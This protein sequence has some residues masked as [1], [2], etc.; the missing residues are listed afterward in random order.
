MMRILVLCNKPPYP[1][2]DGGAIASWGLISSL[3]KAGNEVTVLAM[4]TRKHHV[5]PWDIP[6]EIKSLVTFHLAE[7]SAPINLSGLI[8]NLL[9]S[10]LPYNAER[11]IDK[12]FAKKISD[13][14]S[15]QVFDLVQLEGLYVCPYIPVIRGKSKTLIAYRSHN[16][17]S[18]IWERTLQQSAWP[19]KAYLKVLTQRMKAFELSLL[20]QYDLLIPITQRDNAKLSLMGNKKP[21]LVVPAG[22]SIENV[23]WNVPTKNNDLFFIGALDWGPNTEGL[24]WFFE[25]CWEKLLQRKPGISLSIAGRNAPNWFIRK[26]NRPQ[27]EYL[28]E[29]PDAKKFMQQHGLM[30]APLLSGSGMRIKII[31]AMACKKPIVTTSIGCEGI[32]AT[33]RLNIMIANTPDEF[34]ASV[35]QLIEQPTLA[36]TISENCFTFVENHFSNQKLA[37]KLITFY[38]KQLS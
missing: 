8:R 38:K 13:I 15:H 30:I 33:H 29:V 14:L 16:I 10:K 28:G 27:V 7:V 21:S 2:V 31:E 37:S 22:L 3:A 17:E 35:L 36:A 34:V 18:E 12:S 26:I 5:T 1:P 23:A 9:F 24:L 32:D 11:F 6:E 25:Q 20:N 19:K 4:N